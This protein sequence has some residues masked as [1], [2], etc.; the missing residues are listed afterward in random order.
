MGR[1]KGGRLS[2]RGTVAAA[3]IPFLG[4][5]FP[6][7]LEASF[8]PAGRRWEEP[9]KSLAM[10]RNLPCPS[11]HLPAPHREHRIPGKARGW[12]G[13]QSYPG[14]FHP[15]GSRRRVRDGAFPSP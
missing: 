15:T 12:L 2:Q 9:P 11:T 4:R 5:D 1:W 10:R 14:G 3:G 7:R 6:P 8:C 13:L